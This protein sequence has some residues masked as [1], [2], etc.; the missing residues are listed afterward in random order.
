VKII[1]VEKLDEN[2]AAGGPQE[3]LEL[4]K[5]LLD[6]SISELAKKTPAPAG[7]VLIFD[8][9]DG[10]MIATTLATLQQWKAGV[11]SDAALWHQSFFDP[12]EVFNTSSPSPPIPS[13][14]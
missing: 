4:A 6:K 9:A 2:G 10:G 11:L 5:Y 7:V 1:S 12:P 14:N 3:K 13:A 8:S